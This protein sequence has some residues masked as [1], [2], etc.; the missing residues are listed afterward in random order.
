MWQPELRRWTDAWM[1]AG[2]DSDSQGSTASAA[3]SSAT[4][5][6]F[7]APLWA[8]LA[9]PSKH[10]DIVGALQA[11]GLLGAGGASTTVMASGEQWDAPNAWPPL[12]S[13]LIEGLQQLDASSGGPPLAAELAQRWVGTCYTAWRQT[14]YMHEKYDASR[15]GFGGSGGEYEPQVGFGWSNGAVLQMLRDYGGSLVAP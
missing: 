15:F 5:A 9:I 1:A 7:A 12:Q 10:G 4:L 14:G 2:A 11:S 6:D 13:M 8:G 3:D